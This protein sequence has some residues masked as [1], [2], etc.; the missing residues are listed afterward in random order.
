MFFLLRYILRRIVILNGLLLIYYIYNTKCRS[1]ILASLYIFLGD[2][3]FPWFSCTAG[4]GED[5]KGKIQ[6]GVNTE[7]GCYRK[8]VDFP[9]CLGYDYTTNAGNHN[10]CTLYYDVSSPRIESGGDGSFKFCVRAPNAGNKI[11]SAY[12]KFKESLG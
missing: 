9:Q 8:C 10:P 12:Y 6:T 2:F 5:G 7:K 1:T 11:I 4:R 3:W